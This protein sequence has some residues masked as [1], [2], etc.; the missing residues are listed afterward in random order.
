MGFR[1]VPVVE[2]R[3]VLRLW[4]AGQGVRAIARLAGV[5]RKTVRRYVAAAAAA[6]LERVGGQDQ[7]T[8]DLLGAAIGGARPVRPSGHGSTWALLEEQRG[9]LKEKVEAG[10]R[11]TKVSDLLVRRTGIIVPY[12]TLHRFA[13]SELGF[14]RPRV[15]V[16]VAD[17]DPGRECQADFGRMG[18]IPDEGRQRLLHALIVTAVCSRHTF[19]WLTFR[20]TLEAVIEGLEAAWGFF[21]GVFPVLIP[22]NLKPVV[23]KADPVDPRLAPAFVDYAQARGFV[24]D[25]A[26]VRRPT[27]KPRVERVVP[28][29]RESFFR[30]ESFLDRADAQ[31]RAESWCRGVAGMRIHRTTGRRPAE[32]FAAE[33]QQLLLPA[34]ERP[35]D[36]PIYVTPKVHR[37]FHIEVER[38]LYSVPHAL[39]GERVDVRADSALVK[40]Y[41]RGHL[42]KVH[43]RVT[44]RGRQSDP[45]DFPAERTA[46]AM[47][48]VDHLRRVART[49]GEGVG[50]Y[51]CRL[52]DSP[53]P[54]TRMRQVYRLLGLVRRY[55]AERTEAACS[56]ALELDVVDVTRVARM[57]ERALE[58][59]PRSAPPR[60]GVVVQLRFA[61]DPSEFGS[62]RGGPR[63]DR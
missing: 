33:E 4:C 48:D 18:L 13:V 10:L 35:Y 40:V 3:E 39:V 5:D 25:A 37:D 62:R 42:I 60:R 20:Q 44:G 53:L 58:A 52:L 38:A 24:V 27:D 57:L 30:G 29:V 59:A 23:A 1:E 54:W 56:R 36:V 47:R 22:D 51:A 61:R 19:V 31:R 28:Y 21:G 17:P 16:R 15:T 45:D 55:G 41:H 50:I 32:V 34:P 9:F 26:R 2:V 63:G 8:D 14:G 6:G 12:Q 43:P 7:L 46:Y 49:H 11:L